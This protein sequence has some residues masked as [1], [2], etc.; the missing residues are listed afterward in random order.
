MFRTGLKP[1]LT[2]KKANSPAKVSRRVFGRQA[3]ALSLSPAALLGLATETRE[4]LLERANN[5]LAY[6]TESPSGVAA[7]TTSDVDA[8][9]A[10]VIRK[11]GN[12][13]TGEQRAHLRRIFVYNEKMMDGIRAVS[14]QNADPPASVLRISFA[15]QTAEVEQSP[16]V[17]RK[18]I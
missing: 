1:G 6:Q 3:A 2:P 12:R 4:K 9:L 7:E 17:L 16:P 15:E 5:N 18:R 10:N 11:F 13:L 14:L 8:K